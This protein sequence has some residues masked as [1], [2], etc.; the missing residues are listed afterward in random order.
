[1][2]RAR[3]LS[4]SSSW[5]LNGSSRRMRAM[6]ASGSP[7]VSSDACLRLSFGALSSVPSSYGVLAHDGG[8]EAGDDQKQ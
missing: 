8:D 3:L 2:P 5:R 6:W 1:V 4:P 7:G